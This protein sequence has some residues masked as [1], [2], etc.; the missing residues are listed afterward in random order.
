MIQNIININRNIYK[1]NQVKLNALWDFI[2]IVFLGANS[3]VR[4][5]S[6]YSRKDIRH[7]TY[8]L[9][10]AYIITFMIEVTGHLVYKKNAHIRHT[11]NFTRKVF[12]LIYT[13]VCATAIMLQII[14]TNSYEGNQSLFSNVIKLLFTLIVGTSCLWS[15]IFLKW[16]KKRCKS[17]NRIFS[18]NWTSNY[19]RNY[20]KNISNN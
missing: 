8:A 5:L 16:V 11:L 4:L 12:R 9:M 2:L 3:F 6:T 14:Q 15:K 20:K 19:G 13:G 18:K 1:K 17:I 7:I 10:I